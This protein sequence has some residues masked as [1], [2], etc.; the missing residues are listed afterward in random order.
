MSSEDEGYLNG[1]DS[2][3]DSKLRWGKEPPEWDPAGHEHMNLRSHPRP[4]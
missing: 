4:T 2:K 1:V 3:E